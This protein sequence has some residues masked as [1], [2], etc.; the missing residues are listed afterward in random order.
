VKLAKVDDLGMVLVNGYGRTL[1]I[2]SSEGGGH[3]TCT[4]A[5]GCTAAWPPVLVPAGKQGGTAGTGV[6]ASLLGTA[7]ASDG[8]KYVTYNGWPLYTFNE[9]TGPGQDH[10]QGVTSFGGTWETINAAGKPIANDAS[11]GSSTT[12]T[13]GGSG[14]GSG[15]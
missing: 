11:S 13:S 10:G 14:G 1:Y 2:L 6:T 9:D 8:T 3:I 7:T 15:Y 5:D 12:T 4:A